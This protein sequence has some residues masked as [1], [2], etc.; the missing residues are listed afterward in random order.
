MTLIN[1]KV[2]VEQDSFNYTKLV[3]LV[4]SLIFYAAWVKFENEYISKQ[5]YGPS[6]THIKYFRSLFDIIGKDRAL[7][8]KVI[9]EAISQLGDKFG[10]GMYNGIMIMNQ[11]TPNAFIF[12]IG[13]SLF[14]LFS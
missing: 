13:T 11:N 12:S 4:L 3:I 2:V 1:K 7:V 10:M 6:L 5:L 14:I 8:L 9:L